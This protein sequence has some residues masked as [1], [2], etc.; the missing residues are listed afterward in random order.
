[1]KPAVLPQRH[2]C[3]PGL[4]GLLCHGEALVVP[5]RAGAA[6]AQRGRGVGAQV[7]VYVLAHA[8]KVVRGHPRH[9]PPFEDPLATRVGLRQGGQQE[10]EALEEAL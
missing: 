3:A 2:G 9:Q 6:G 7:G 1:M 8:L 5:D 4:R 10:V